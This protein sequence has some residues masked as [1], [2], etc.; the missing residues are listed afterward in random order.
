MKHKI[1]FSTLMSFTLS[2]LMTAWVTYI[3]LGWSELYFQQ[4]MNAFI[5]ASQ[6]A[7]VISFV[8]ARRLHIISDRI[9]KAKIFTKAE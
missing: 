4:W 3:N 1:I 2:F 9:V 6:A 8:V 7:F 5:L